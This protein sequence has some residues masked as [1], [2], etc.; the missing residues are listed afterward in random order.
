MEREES[1]ALTPPREQEVADLWGRA[2]ATHAS[3]EDGQENLTATHQTLAGHGY[4]THTF[5][6][7]SF[8]RSPQKLLQRSTGK[9][10][11][12]VRGNYPLLRTTLLLQQ[13]PTQT[14]K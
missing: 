5:P 11:R 13:R 7:R 14:P 9:E 3:R 1:L 10:A 8:P 6:D 4:A 2:I 12:Y